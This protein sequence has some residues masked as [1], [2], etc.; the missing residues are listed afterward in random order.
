[1]IANA[2]PSSLG[3]MPGAKWDFDEDVTHVFDDM[4]ERS[5]PD[6]QQMRT[7]T[8]DLAAKFVQRDSTI[9]DLGCS[10]GEALQLLAQK[11]GAG[12]RYVGLE[13][14]DPMLEAAKE[15]FASWPK[16]VVEI[17]KHDLRDGLPH[18]DA[19]VV[20]SVLTLM[21]TPI[22]YR[23]R[24]IQDAYDRLRPGGA[25]LL[26]EK[27]IGESATTDAL[28]VERY[29]RMKA[30]NGYSADEIERKRLALEGVQVPVTASWNIEMMH[31]AGFR[32]VECYW[33]WMNFAAWVAVKDETSRVKT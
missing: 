2:K 19:S 3:H 25:F 8:T 26:V 22:N 33:R 4:L 7:L 12:H 16:S 9:L 13:I 30:D 23:Q 11:F 24:L 6:Y 15:R 1:M 31:A 18:V 10:R 21:F 27:L 28:M 17:R 5:I 32:M 20:L 29:H 14:S